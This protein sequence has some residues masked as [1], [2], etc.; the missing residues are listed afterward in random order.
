[1]SLEAGLYWGLLVMVLGAA[2]VAGFALYLRAHNTTQHN[3]LRG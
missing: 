2:S 3:T 1:M